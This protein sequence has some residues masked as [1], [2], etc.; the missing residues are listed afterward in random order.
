MTVILQLSLP[1]KK[2]HQKAKECEPCYDRDNFE[3]I[4]IYLG[5]YIEI[6]VFY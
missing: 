1:L 4:L 2:V 3:C 6:F 5:K